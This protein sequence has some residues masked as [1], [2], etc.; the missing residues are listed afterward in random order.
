MNNL[1]NLLSR[2]GQLEEAEALYLSHLQAFQSGLVER[3]PDELIAYNNLGI[4]Y[5][6]FIIQCIHYICE[7]I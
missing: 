4:L 3:S 6:Y 7:F 1:A 2:T 5:Y